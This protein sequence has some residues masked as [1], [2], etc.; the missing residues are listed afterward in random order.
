MKF[1]IL[2]NTG[3]TLYTELQS[4]MKNYNSR[5]YYDIKKQLQCLG[6]MIIRAEEALENADRAEQQRLNEYRHVGN[7]AVRFI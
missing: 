6:E 3:N 7:D 5:N 4:A 1:S 2:K